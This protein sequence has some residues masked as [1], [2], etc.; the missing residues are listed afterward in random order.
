MY[1]HFNE[2]NFEKKVQEMKKNE[3]VNGYK[4]EQKPRTGTMKPKIDEIR[5]MPII[6]WKFNAI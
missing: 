4:N 6:P 5:D 3:K 1:P 2:H